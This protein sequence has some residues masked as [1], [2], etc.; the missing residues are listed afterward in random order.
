MTSQLHL[1]HLATQKL[2]CGYIDLPII[3]MTV[4]AAMLHNY[5]DMHTVN[6]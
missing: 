6:A 3:L 5:K 2:R 4:A 1:G